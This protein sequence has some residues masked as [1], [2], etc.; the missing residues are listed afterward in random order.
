MS[1]DRAEICGKK[2]LNL[3]STNLGENPCQT[4]RHLAAL[5]N[6]ILTDELDLEHLLSI[7][8]N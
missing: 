8:E 5:Y 4:V 3:K 6:I 1:L 2:K 7:G